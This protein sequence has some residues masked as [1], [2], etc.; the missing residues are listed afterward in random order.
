MLDGPLRTRLESFSFSSGMLIVTGRPWSHKVACLEEPATTPFTLYGFNL[1]PGTRETIWPPSI[2][3]PW[4]TAD[5]QPW[6]VSSMANDDGAPPGTGARI[7]RVWWLDVANNQA[8]EDV[9]MNG[10]VNVQMVATTVRRVNRMEVLTAGG[11]ERVNRGNI[12]LYAT[13]AATIIGYMPLYYCSSAGC[14]QT[15]PAG[16]VDV[17]TGWHL[18]W[19][20]PNV[21]VLAQLV[22]RTAPDQPWEVVDEAKYGNELDR[23]F[24]VPRVFNAGTDYDVW[25]TDASSDV[26]VTLVGYRRAV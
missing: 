10:V 14:F 26:Y 7:V 17:I 23:P 4:P 19:N 9:V 8:F 25:G 22:C 11:T 6:I 20:A 1:N 15:V 16:F 13:D 5:Q 2:N 24:A 12:T 18:S 3:Y 21:A